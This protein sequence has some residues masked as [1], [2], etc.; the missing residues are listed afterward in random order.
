M[1]RIEAHKLERGKVLVII[2]LFVRSNFVREHVKR[3]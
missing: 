1:L 2:P 3:N